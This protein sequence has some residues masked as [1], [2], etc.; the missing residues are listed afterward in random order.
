MKHYAEA[1]VSLLLSL[2]VRAGALAANVKTHGAPM[3]A[4][5]PAPLPVI[6]DNATQPGDSVAN[7]KGLPKTPEE[8]PKAPF[9]RLLEGAGDVAKDAELRRGA[10]FFPEGAHVDVDIPVNQQHE[11]DSIMT[12]EP[13]VF[14]HCL[15]VRD[16]AEPFRVG[17]SI[18]SQPSRFYH[19]GRHLRSSHVRKPDGGDDEDDSPDEKE[20]KTSKKE[21]EEDDDEEEEGPQSD[22]ST[23]KKRLPNGLLKPVGAVSD[24]DFADDD[25]DPA[26]KNRGAEFSI[27]A[28]AYLQ[29]VAGEVSVVPHGL[30]AKWTSKRKVP[31]AGYLCTSDGGD[32]SGPVLYTLPT[33]CVPTVL[34]DDG[35]AYEPPAEDS[36]PFIPSPA[37][38][39]VMIPTG[40]KDKSDDDEELDD[41][42]EVE[43]A[44]APAAALLQ[45]NR[46]HLRHKQQSNGDSN[47]HYHVW[48]GHT[49]LK[50]ANRK[51]ANRFCHRLA[52]KIAEDPGDTVWDDSL[53]SKEMRERLTGKVDPSVSSFVQ[54]VRQ[55]PEKEWTVGTKSVLVVVMDWAVGDTSRA[56]NSQQTLTPH[57][58]KTKIFP[59]VR[60]AFQKMSYGQFDISV[61]VVP[62]V[63]RFTRQRS[64][65]TA[66]GYP[67]PGLYNGARD[68]LEGHASLGTQYRFDDYDLVYV[69]SPQQAPTGTKGVAWVGAKGAMCNGCEEISENFQVMVAV[70]ELGHNLGLSHAS[71]RSLEYGN[72]FDWMGNY[73]DVD[74]LSYGVGY[75]LR[76]SWIPRVSVYSITDSELGDLN[77]EFTLKPFD[78]SAPGHGDLVGVQVS[79]SDAPRDV[80]I[81]YRATAGSNAGVYITLQDKDSPNS[82]LVDCACHSPSQQDARLRPG[83][84]YLD[85]TQ[86]F[87]VYLAS[88]DE[89]IA[90]V[91]IYK[92]PTSSSDIAKIR[93]RATFTDGAWKCPRT[94]TDSDLLV[95]VYNGCGPLAQG[96]YCNGGSI[97]M[98][99]TKYSIADDL[100]PS[101]CDKCNDVMSGSTL[102]DG[103]CQDRNIK[104]S[105][106]T[107]P[108]AAS[109]GYC[110]Y[111][112]NLG[113]IGTDLCPASCGNCP[114]R[115]AASNEA[116]T[117]Q[118]PSP[119][120]RHGAASAAVTGV[121]EEEEQEADKKEEEE[122]EEVSDQQSD[123]ENGETDESEDYTC[124]D[125]PQWSDGDGDGC[126][127]YRQYIEEGKM[128]QSEACDYGDGAGKIYCRKTCDTCEAQAI[129]DTCVDKKCVAK[130]YEETGQCFECAA[131]ATHCHEDYFKADCPATCHTCEALTREV[132]T[133]APAE[134]PATTT[135]TT[136]TTTTAA[137]PTAPKKCEDKECVEAWLDMHGECFKCQD[138]AQEFC[139]KD[140]LF[141]E[142]C[143]R[144]CRMCTPGEE[145][146]CRDDFRPHVCKRFQKFG[147]CGVS[148]VAEHCAASCGHCLASGAEDSEAPEAPLEPK[149]PKSSHAASSV[150]MPLWALFASAVLALL[151]CGL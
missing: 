138:F 93:A 95:S 27:N 117:F 108:E 37:P 6:L 69:I 41:E 147:W 3:F 13:S 84:T 131:Y 49:K 67:F 74:G 145:H 99:G 53:M 129:R 58:Y 127:I 137:M 109:L 21:K 15:L 140:V 100:C 128:T 32:Q 126:H 30:I 1:T 102:V 46:T 18:M 10:E 24:R 107:C 139:G 51:K 81:G 150:V 59:R 16:Y 50:F 52:Q 60:E 106:H 105:G 122:K 9:N 23:G 76:L 98:G 112:T 141:M 133:S 149:W 62:Q 4:P 86:S 70:H 33:P 64:R 26:D 20:E 88:V 120:R 25:T 142:S 72:V 42:E 38:A 132:A 66:G 101:S 63:V 119:A 87:V 82:E 143:P 28:F 36:P 56:P 144:S 54:Q 83:W 17:S 78:N 115:P 75:K 57:H 22:S 45:A 90:T 29:S 148:H 96:G 80:F 89:D 121:S 111:T 65:Y 114:P 7:G 146:E 79:L 92:A 5:A 123:E 134:A 113:N 44:K 91:R 2:L 110:S 116:A 97:T 31:I 48:V 47:E 68:S 135:T 71:S 94:C 85:P 136:T 40:L 19:Q 12:R 118:D 14:G 8:V 130:W 73:P 35:T 61:T 39:P 34:G 43:D 124:M 103:G 125:D 151:R 104:I 55:T 11:L 77:D